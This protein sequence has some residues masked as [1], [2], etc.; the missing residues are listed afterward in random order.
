MKMAAAT[1]AAHLDMCK[2]MTS[3]S[4]GLWPMTCPDNFFWRGPRVENGP[5]YSAAAFHTPYP[6][7]ATPTVL[8]TNASPLFSPREVLARGQASLNI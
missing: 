4:G 3:R 1:R 5:A 8:C 7:T 2:Q 6:R